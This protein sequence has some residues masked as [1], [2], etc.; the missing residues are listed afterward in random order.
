MKVSTRGRY[1]L[2][3]MMA[4]AE[5]YGRGPLAVDAIAK[6]ENLSANYIHIL[7]QSLRAAGLVHA[8]RGPGGG[9][10]L[11]RAPS[12]ITA[13]DVVA[14]VEGSFEPAPCVRDE[15]SCGR[16]EGCAA[17]ELWREV[18]KAIDSVLSAVSI[19][20]LARRQQAKRNVPLHYD[21]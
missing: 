16:I 14:V 12:S 7:A 11:Q 2:R 19:E 17:H 9:Y 18:A 20:E 1:G 8:V 21:I 10:E 13:K 5:H 4:L 3:L 6:S 15:N